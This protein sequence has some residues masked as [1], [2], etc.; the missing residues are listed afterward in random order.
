MGDFVMTARTASGDKFGDEPARSRYLVVPDN[1]KE[2][3]PAHTVKVK[4][5]TEAVM[6]EAAPEVTGGPASA[7]GDI[8]FFVH[9]FN[10][11]PATVLERHRALKSGLAK[12]GYEGTVVSFDWPSGDTGLGYIEDRVD[13]K[14]SALQLVSDGVLLLVKY[15]TPTC[16]INVHVLAHSMGAFVTREAFDDADDRAV[17]ADKS[18]MVSQILLIGGDVSA[19]SMSEGESSSSS[20]Y[21]HCIRLTNYSN[22]NDVPLGLSNVKRAG[23]KPRVGRWGLPKD[24][25]ASAVNV[26]C[27]DYWKTIPKNQKIIGDRSHSW[28]IGDPVFMEDLLRTVRGEDRLALPTRRLE[29]DRLVMKRPGS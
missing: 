8:L 27:S 19:D 28:H 16:P 11:S 4:E 21:R 29:G 20:L 15:Q 3:L 26:D 2:S 14:K 17:A 13:G 22:R 24:A 6:A 23:V 12:L 10:N 7:N 9:G 1:A 18:W 25:P 5:W